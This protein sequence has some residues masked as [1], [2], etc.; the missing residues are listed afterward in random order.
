MAVFASYAKYYNLLYQDKNY[1]DEAN[2][3]DRL[4]QKYAPGAKTILDLGC[5]TGRHDIELAR[6][7]YTLTG[8]DMSQ[9]MLALARDALTSCDPQFKTPEFYH[10]D[11]R[12]FRLGHLFDTVVAL[13]HVMSYQSTNEDLRQA[14]ETAAAH[15]K[16]GGLF[17]FDCWYGPGVLCDPPT[18]RV[19]ELE[20]DEIAVTRIA[21]PVVHL[22]E[23]IVDVGYHIFI[24]DKK[25]QRVEEV[26]ETHRMRY[27]FYPE[28]ED[29]LKNYGFDILN[30]MEFMKDTPPEKGNWNVCFVCRK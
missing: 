30:F 16:T 8:V 13:F 9:E 1:E 24:R 22:H 29:I 12:T 25:T 3:V 17:I 27:L 28:V 18:V 10:G 4:V 23:N 2:Y 26:R 11:I 7:G 15:L 19:K 5:G 21:E 6:K 14:F 20:D